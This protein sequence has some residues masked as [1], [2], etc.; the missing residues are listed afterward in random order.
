MPSIFEKKIFTN[1]IS[2]YVLVSA[3]YVVIAALGHIGVTV[4]P[5]MNVTQ[6]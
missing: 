5:T 6:Y 4:L 1:V 3:L 2:V